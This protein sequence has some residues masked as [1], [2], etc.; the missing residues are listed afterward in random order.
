MTLLLSTGTIHMVFYRRP[1]DFMAY[2]KIMSNIY[3][4]FTS[5]SERLAQPQRRFRSQKKS[6]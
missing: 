3:C 1:P 5:D 6:S 2:F 4:I